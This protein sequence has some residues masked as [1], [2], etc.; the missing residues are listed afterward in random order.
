[1]YAHI[2]WVSFGQ[3]EATLNVYTERETHLHLSSKC[4][5]FVTETEQ[6][7]SGRTKYNHYCVLGG[8]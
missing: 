7:A 8:E 6:K 4:S 5:E 1:M 2:S 3:E